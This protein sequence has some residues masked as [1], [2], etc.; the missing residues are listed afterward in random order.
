[1][2]KKTLTRSLAWL[3]LGAVLPLLLFAGGV[4]LWM[5]QDNAAERDRALQDRTRALA[6]AVDREIA[7]WKTTASTMAASSAIQQRRWTEFYTEAR[8]VGTDLGGWFALSDGTQQLLNTL[9]PYGSPLPK[10]HPEVQEVFRNPQPYI[11]DPFLGPVTQRLTIAV[12]VPVRR[13]GA[14]TA[15]LSLAIDPTHLNRLLESQALPATWVAALVDRQTRVVARSRDAASRIGKPGPEPLR[16]AT[17]AAN[18]GLVTY[19]LIDGRPARVAF[20][21]LTEVPWVLVLAVPVA[22]LPS[23]RPLLLFLGIALGLA[24]VAVGLATVVA[25]RIARPIRQLAQQAPAL[26]AGQPPAFDTGSAMR[27]VTELQ[28]A[29]LQAAHSARAAFEAR[30]QATRAEERAQAAAASEQAIRAREQALQA[31]EERYR[32]LVEL[33]PD[34]ILVFHPDGQIVY[35]NPAA[36]RLY[37]AADASALLGTP[38]LDRVHPDDRP[39]AADR[40]RQVVAGAAAPTQPLRH[41]RLDGRPVPVESL[42]APIEWQGRPAVQA[43]VRDMTARLEAEAALAASE[44]SRRQE[45]EWLR[46]TLTS[47]GDAVLATDTAG[48]LTFLNPVAETLTG[49]PQAE[50]VGQTVQ[51]VFNIIDERTQAAAVDIV[52]QVLREGRTVLLA[53][54]TALV[55]RGG[56]IVPIED[57]A[58]PIRDGA[59]RVA[60][61][62]VVFHD[63]T[64]KRAAQAA[65]RQ[66]HD[67]LE[68]TVARR[69]AELAAAVERL[70]HEV[71]QRQQAE[72]HLQR[73]NR[74]LRLLSACNEALVRLDD[75][76][77]LTREVCRA[78]VEIGEYRM[79]WVGLAEADDARTVRPVAAMGF[80]EG[81]LE[82]AQI[83][84]ADI[85]RGQGPTGTAI[86]TG[87]IQIG[88]DFLSEPRLAPWKADALARGFRSSIALPLRG[89]DHVLGALTIYAA[90]PQAF[91]EDEIPVLRELADDLAFGIL[92]VRMR[93][94]LRESRDRLRAL[95]GELTLAEQ[96]E[97]HRLAKVLHDNLQQLLVAARIRA[98]LLVRAHPGLGQPVEEIET[99]LGESL[100]VSRSLNAEL[101]PMALHAGG[102]PAGLE[103]LAGWMT[104]KHGLK[105]DLAVDADVSPTA[106]DVKVLVFESVRELLFN[107]VKHA[108]TSV[109][110]L[111]GRRLPGGQLELVVAD[112]GLGF[113]P[114]QLA[115]KGAGATGFGLFSIRERL[116]LI[117]GHLAVASRPGEGSRFT[118]TAPLGQAPATAPPSL[119]ATAAGPSGLPKPAAPLP[120]RD[121]RIRIVLADDHAVVRQ[122]L[123]RLLAAE[124]DFEVIGEAEDGKRAI[125]LARELAP[126]IL[127]MDVNMPGLDGVQ[128]T[129]CIRTEAP[130]VRVIGLSMFREFEQADAMRA[131][132]A[133]TYLSKSDPSDTLLAAIRFWASASHGPE[134][135]PA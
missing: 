82:R 71:E 65:L 90:E 108:G 83:S 104:Q 121:G 37:G 79:A 66:A 44:A 47:I 124:P 119:L 115:A 97:R 103:W 39:L 10:S 3:V 107:V 9:V 16:R 58:A 17:A 127:V 123:S 135:S 11:R 59:G 52:Q 117:G 116:E 110:S 18:S 129:Q 92:A 34:A 75:E 28:Q 130:N 49:W 106:E 105:V 88:S 30:A 43:I 64:E 63:V 102:L 61:V 131:A 46:V 111:R 85:P 80:E 87:A 78:V 86:R 133:V 13:A 53:N 4:L 2:P 93:G 60:G 54:H 27:E 72:V 122:A 84:W 41:L 62:V 74:V 50:A 94:A 25:R 101:S 21:R 33:A 68:R 132:G 14:V 8:D 73:T 77:A 134:A 126:D 57:S 35:A 118:L 100:T 48:R 56:R 55:A 113:D 99:L 109:V 42:A 70:E 7:A 120:A 89:G 40:I 19:P 51:T 29:L 38:I 12:T 112:T 20:Q 76:P 24:G 1:M 125:E 96:R 69:T 45:H 114:A 98:Q 81:Y 6:L 15:A 23:P 91:Q 95:T 67:D 32:G 36:A 31:S 26:V 5:R 22:E 128:A